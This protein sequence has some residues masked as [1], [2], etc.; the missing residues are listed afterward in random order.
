M[1]E[2][3]NG[4]LVF[5]LGS[6]IGPASFM[7][8]RALDYYKRRIQVD[9]RASMVTAFEQQLF[10]PELMR[11]NNHFAFLSWMRTFRGA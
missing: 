9:F 8:L 7:E 10:P 11:E 4:K 6:L 1:E 3:P 2:H 5:I